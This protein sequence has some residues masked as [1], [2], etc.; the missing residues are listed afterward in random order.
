MILGIYARLI[1]DA[2]LDVNI[3]LGLVM[4]RC[5]YNL[6]AKAH[7]VGGC[8]EM[9]NSSQAGWPFES[10]RHESVVESLQL[11]QASSF[12]VYCAWYICL[13]EVWDELKFDELNKN[14]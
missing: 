5:C 10:T 2:A 4:R 1:A 14:A 7:R 11:Q 3:R 8:R 6:L 13:S 12:V 9:G